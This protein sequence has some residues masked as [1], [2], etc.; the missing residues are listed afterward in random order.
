MV[1]KK[2]IKDPKGA[3]GFLYRRGVWKAD[4]YMSKKMYGNAS[5]F[6]SNFIGRKKL[7]KNNLKPSK[8]RDNG[9]DALGIPYEKELIE[10]IISKYNKLILDEKHAIKRMNNG[11]VYRIELKN[12]IKAIPELGELINKKIIDLLEDYYGSHFDVKVVSCW[13]NYHIKNDYIEGTKKE[14]FSSRWH[15]DRLSVEKAKLFVNLTNVTEQ[16]GPFHLQ[17]RPR[18]KELIKMGFGS[19]E[20]YKLSQDI[21]EDP[22]H[23]VKA[24]GPPGSAIFA[25]TSFCFHR[26]GVPEPGHYRDI[27]EFVFVPSSEPLPKDWI[28]HIDPEYDDGNP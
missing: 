25:N 4:H 16:D 2:S 20:D 17:P 13:R 1:L 9:Y 27:V 8:F 5:G 19:R 7:S 18:T 23:V 22:K 11:E 28:K 26:A 15:C 12:S 14:F 10:R 6:L 3:V 21:L 24:T